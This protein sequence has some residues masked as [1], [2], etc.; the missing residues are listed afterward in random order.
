MLTTNGYEY[1]SPQECCN[2]GGSR[3][4]YA[5]YD[6]SVLHCYKRVCL[7]RH[8]AEQR[9]KVR[10]NFHLIEIQISC[11]FNFQTFPM[12]KCSF[13]KTCTIAQKFKD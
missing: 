12:W 3:D 13:D 1:R 8:F 10:I 9:Q 7:P 2:R 11:N 6:C 4:C 5:R